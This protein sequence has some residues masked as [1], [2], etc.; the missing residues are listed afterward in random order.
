MASAEVTVA[1]T[2]LHAITSEMSSLLLALGASGCPQPYTAV[3]ASRG[4]MI[5]HSGGGRVLPPLCLGRPRA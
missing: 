2:S 1:L 5:Y 4:G 3:V